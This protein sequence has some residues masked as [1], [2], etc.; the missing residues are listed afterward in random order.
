MSTHPWPHH[1]GHGDRT[2]WL[3]TGFVAGAIAVLVFDQGAIAM[4][5]SIGFTDVKPFSMARTAPWGLPAVWSSAFWGGVWGVLLALA[6]ARLDGP[7]LVAASIAF[8]AILP[9]LV[10]WFIVAP[11]K[12]RA[13]AAGF[14]PAAM[15][16][17]L[18][19][20]GAWGLGTGSGLLLFGR[21]HARGYTRSI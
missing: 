19:A 16:V 10:A 9:T 21:A 7:A 12:G 15:M 14:A 1:A 20:N 3:V 4:L 13:M 8:G 2:R 11:L 17:G 5:H 18:I 6:L